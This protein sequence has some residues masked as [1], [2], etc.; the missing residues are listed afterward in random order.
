MVPEHPLI[1][2]YKVL[3]LPLLPPVL[4][5]CSKSRS[6]GSGG[7]SEAHPT[8]LAGH[9]AGKGLMGSPGPDS[10]APE[11]AGGAGLGAP[12][13]LCV[14]HPRRPCRWTGKTGARP[15]RTRG[16]SPEPHTR[17][18]HGKTGIVRLQVVKITPNQLCMF[19][20]PEGTGLARLGR[21][22]ACHEP[23][24]GGHAFYS[25]GRGGGS[26]RACLRQRARS[27][28]QHLKTLVPKRREG[29]RAYRGQAPRA[30]FAPS[31]ARR[32]AAHA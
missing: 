10:P 32:R 1:N 12:R 6:E 25:A 19:Y 18:I 14:L 9:T 16:S 29:E 23:A 17:N 2:K 24:G 26:Q 3:E 21:G 30:R 7:L 20:V 8:E 28:T 31:E 22:A 15:P 5:F 4:R 11:P 27:S 13:T